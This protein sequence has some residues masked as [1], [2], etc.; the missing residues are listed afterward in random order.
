M[1]TL[2]IDLYTARK[3]PVAQ[4]ASWKGAGE[5]RE[6]QLY[7]ILR[8][9]MVNFH[10]GCKETKAV[11]DR[12][13]STGVWIL[14]S[15]QIGTESIYQIIDSDAFKHILELV[16]VSWVCM[17]KMF[18]ILFGLDVQQLMFLIRCTQLDLTCVRPVFSICLTLVTFGKDQ[19]SGASD[20]LFQGHLLLTLG[21]F[22]Q[23]LF[24]TNV[25]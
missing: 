7:L 9:M 6:N 25:A 21:L 12:R 24:D 14:G 10:L 15:L 2:Q 13:Y 18:H 8:W 23:R 11:L 22:R 20:H 4:K 1:K 16:T 17:L 3:Q 19:L 5:L